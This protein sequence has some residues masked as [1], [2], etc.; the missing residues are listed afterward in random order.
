MTKTATKHS[1]KEEQKKLMVRIICIA[2]VV[3]MAVTTLLAMFPSL[4]QSSTSSE[5][6]S[7]ID[8]G[9]AYVGEDGS[10]YLTDAGLEWLTSG[11]DT[12]AEEDH[13]DHDHE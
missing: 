11:T 4:F 9:Y 5:W 7:M 6:Q 2:I 10:I 12:T 3:V 8:A 1:K 13:A